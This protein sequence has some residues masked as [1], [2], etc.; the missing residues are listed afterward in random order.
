[1]KNRIKLIRKNSNLTQS[2]FAKRLG[3]VQNTITGYETGRRNPSGSAITLMCREF[4]I[5]EDWL[6]DGTG[7]MYRTDFDDNFQA[8]MEDIGANDPKARQFILDYWHLSNSDKELFRRFV[9]KFL[10]I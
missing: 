9:N 6:R 10:K 7:E 8:V 3:T 1:M 4:N 2:E 5:N